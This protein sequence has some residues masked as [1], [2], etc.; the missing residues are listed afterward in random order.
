M[1]VLQEYYFRRIS[2]F[3]PSQQFN[4]STSKLIS[5]LKFKPSVEIMCKILVCRENHFENVIPSR[6][7]VD[8]LE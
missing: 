1:K 4:I 5:A 6:W 7:M 2:A 3:R 8:K